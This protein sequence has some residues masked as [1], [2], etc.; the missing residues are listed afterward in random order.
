[1]FAARP[2]RAG[3]PITTRFDDGGFSGGTLERPALQ[4]LLKAIKARRV[5]VVV[6]Y[7]I[8]RLSRS[9]MDFA[10]LADV[11]DAHQVSFVSVTQSFNTTTSMGRLMLNVLLSF[12]QFER[13]ITGERIRDKI[14]A[15][16]QKGLWMGGHVPFGYRANGRSLVPDN[17]EADTVRSLYRLYL[18]HGTV[19]M[20]HWEAARLGLMTRQRTWSDGRITGGKAFCRGH[21]YR[22]LNNPLY[23]GRI[24]HKGQSYPGNHPGLVD[25]ETWETVQARLA[26]NTLGHKTGRHARHPSLLAG[27]LVDP[28]GARFRATQGVKKG[29]TYRYYSHPAVITGAKGERLPIRHVPATDVD[30]AVLNALKKLLSD[31]TAM[32]VAL[33]DGGTGVSPTVLRRASDQLQDIL[34]HR[35]PERIRALQVLVLRIELTPDALR[36]Q[37]DRAGLWQS[38]GIE[39]SV[40]F[41][42]G[43]PH[44]IV[45]PVELRSRQGVLR[46]I[47]E[48]A[49]TAAAPRVDL[50]LIQMLAR[51]YRWWE[52]IETGHYRSIQALADAERLSGSYVTRVIRLTFLAPAV[53]ADIVRGQQPD[54]MSARKLINHPALPSEWDAQRHELDARYPSRNRQF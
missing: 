22:V 29:R 12:A 21:I 11:F 13:E 14:A 45:V 54:G 6:I 17:A 16:K 2:M 4:A 20:V 36:L 40:A 35:L 49:R 38:L 18:E 19:R 3:R 8:D 32:M 39:R 10:Q 41:P 43:E 46:L 48:P 23:V 9:L 7:K 1:M 44:D 31:P 52:Q 24:C 33:G 34:N 25:L 30:T 28:D 51:G 42:S 15:S 27:L 5:D 37:I 47:F 50:V 26:D 53:I